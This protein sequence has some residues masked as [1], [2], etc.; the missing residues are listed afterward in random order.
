MTQESI[1]LLLFAV[2][3]YGYYVLIDYSTIDSV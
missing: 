1:I 3:Y 2:A